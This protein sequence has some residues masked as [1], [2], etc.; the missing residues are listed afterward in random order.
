MG[1]KPQATLNPHLMKGNTTM[2]SALIFGFESQR[3]YPLYLT[4]DPIEGVSDEELY[5]FVSE[6]LKGLQAVSSSET[7]QFFLLDEYGDV[8]AFE[9]TWELTGSLYKA[10]EKELAIY[11]IMKLFKKTANVTYA[12]H[13]GEI[14]IIAEVADFF[15]N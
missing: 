6:N 1:V 15:D 8:L 10:D 2:S 14:N 12:D 4:I 7:P 5:P 9:D 13:R 11:S 3:P